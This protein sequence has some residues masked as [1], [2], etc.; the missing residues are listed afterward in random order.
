MSVDVI[1]LSCQP[2]GLLVTVDKLL[3]TRIVG[4]HAKRTAKYRKR[5]NRI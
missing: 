4:A 5:L 2:E 3:P 1:K